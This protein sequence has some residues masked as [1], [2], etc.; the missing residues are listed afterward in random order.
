MEDIRYGVLTL[1]PTCDGDGL[2]I[3]DCEKNATEV[4]IPAEVNGLPVVGIGDVAFEYCTVLSRVIFPDDINLPAFNTGEPIEEWERNYLLIG[5]GFEIGGNAFMGCTSLIEIDL[6]YY[7]TVIGHGAFYKCESLT[8]ATFTDNAF[9]SSYAFSHCYSLTEVST[10][11]SVNDGVF[12][13][14]KSLNYLPISN[15]TYTIGEDAFEHCYSL[16]E[17]TIPKQ[18]TRIE[19]LA[20]R[21]CRGLTRVVFESPDGWVG[22]NAYMRGKKNKLDLSNPEHNALWLSRMDFDD[23]VIAWFKDDGDEDGDNEDE[24][25]PFDI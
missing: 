16:R 14:C 9:V 11:K 21:S 12:S 3:C 2:I 6:P 23:G 8:K 4:V 19:A 25:D 15:Y 18:V 24:F 13:H 22:T 10:V 1:T 5:C 17:I 7:V 20:F